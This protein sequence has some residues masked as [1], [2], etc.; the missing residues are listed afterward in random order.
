MEL[1]IFLIWQNF[2]FS[3]KYNVLL[4]KKVDYSGHCPLDIDPSYK[5]SVRKR[6]LRQESKFEEDKGAGV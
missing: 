3:E 5:N 4:C 6:G 1:S 2:H